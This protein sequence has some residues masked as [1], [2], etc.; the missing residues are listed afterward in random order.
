MLQNTQYERRPTSRAS[1]WHAKMFGIPNPA[2][3]EEARKARRQ[4]T[5][6][7]TI[8]SSTAVHADAERAEVLGQAQGMVSVCV[9]VCVCV[10][11]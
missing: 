11:V 9:C 7:T 5:I 4:P 6:A 8:T 10:C 3:E 1:A 2:K